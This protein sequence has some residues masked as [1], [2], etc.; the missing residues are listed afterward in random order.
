MEL[1][2]I[3]K[4]LENLNVLDVVSRRTRVSYRDIRQSLEE[5]QLVLQTLIDNDYHTDEDEM[6]LEALK[7]HPDVQG[8]T[9]PTEE[10]RRWACVQA[11]NFVDHN[12]AEKTQ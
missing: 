7:K 5:L 3:D 12:Q 6:L 11:S 9:L 2:Q 1:E 10:D 4:V 8:Y